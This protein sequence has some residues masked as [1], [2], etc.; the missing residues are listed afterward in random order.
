MHQVRHENS[1]FSDFGSATSGN[2][3]DCGS[4][5]HGLVII[6]ILDRHAY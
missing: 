4:R 3:G 6:D 2:Y 1:E 5:Q